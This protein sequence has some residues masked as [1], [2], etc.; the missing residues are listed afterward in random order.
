VRVYIREIFHEAVA[1]GARRKAAAREIGVSLRTLQRWERDEVGDRRQG[2]RTEPANKLSEAERAR[3]L[4]V[5]TSR[6]FRDLSP[7]QIVPTLADRGEYVASESSFYRVLRDAKCQRHRESARPPRRRPRALA[8]TG[9]NQVWSWDITYLPSAVRGRFLRLYVVVD[10]WSRMIVGWAVHEAETSEHAAVLIKR[11]ARA[12]GVPRGELTLHS[13]N[14][15]PMKGQTM[16]SMLQ[17]LGIAASF[18]RPTVKDDNPYS[19]SLFRTLKY[20]PRYPRG[21][22]AD[23]DAARAW[24]TGF[25]A[26]YNHEH[27]HSAIR[28]VTPG[29][30]HAGRDTAILEKRRRIYLAARRRHPERWSRDI[31]NWT[32]V[33]Q[34]HLNPEPGKVAAA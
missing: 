10:V 9:P 5:A 19:E 25:V 3:I 27:L 15:S 30:R 34:V 32:P 28:F 8:A 21:R 29:D 14:G 11:A 22:F 13:D 6:E 7:K 26:W 16:L 4:Q 31:R 23:L 2:P 33:R 12:Q 20:R 17:W 1:A 24:V 18:S